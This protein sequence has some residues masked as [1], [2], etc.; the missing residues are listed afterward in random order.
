MKARAEELADGYQEARDQEFN[1]Q[2]KDFTES[3]ITNSDCITEDDVQGF[4]DSFT[5]PNEADWAWDKMQNEIED[6]GDQQYQ[7]CKDEGRCR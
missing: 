6:I 3:Y 7:L 5:F 1:D 2:F 4:M